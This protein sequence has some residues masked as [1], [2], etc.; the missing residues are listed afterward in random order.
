[1]MSQPAWQPLTRLLLIADAIDG[2][3]QALRSRCGTSSGWKPSRTS[4]I[5]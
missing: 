1:M 5:Q 4:W 2:M 3:Q